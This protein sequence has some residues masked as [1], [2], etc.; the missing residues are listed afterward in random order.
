[1][2]D[3]VQKLSHAVRTLSYRTTVRLRIRY[4]LL[5]TDGKHIIIINGRSSSNVALKAAF[6]TFALRNAHAYY[7][8]DGGKNVIMFRT[9]PSQPA[10][11]IMLANI[12]TNTLGCRFCRLNL[13]CVS[14]SYLAWFFTCTQRNEINIIRLNIIHNY[15]KPLAR[16]NFDSLMVVFSVVGVPIFWRCKNNCFFSLFFPVRFACFAFFRLSFEVSKGHL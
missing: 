11:C 9:W 1:M 8:W 3:V 2:L 5:Y 4:R 7:T 16:R 10:Q 15:H 13:D 6:S 14:S 12:N